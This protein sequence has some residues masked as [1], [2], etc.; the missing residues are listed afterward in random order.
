MGFLQNGIGMADHLFGFRVDKFS[1]FGES[2][3]LGAAV[4]SFTSRGLS[5][6]LNLLGHGMRYIEFT[7]AFKKLPLSAT[8]IKVS[9]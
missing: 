9:K 2:K 3:S 5:R 8:W 7:A 4:K 1:C 6:R